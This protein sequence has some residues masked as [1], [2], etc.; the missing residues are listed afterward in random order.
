MGPL[1]Y[2]RHWTRCFCLDSPRERA[3]RRSEADAFYRHT[4]DLFFRTDAQAVFLEPYAVNP[5]RG[6]PWEIACPVA[7][8]ARYRERSGNDAYASL[9]A[10][11]PGAR[12]R[13]ATIV[14]ATRN[15][16]IQPSST[17]QCMYR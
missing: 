5:S 11:R 2:S 7:A 9:A 15:S 14:S 3:H 6:E 10:R 16:M 17:V 13:R 8:A 12:A 4:L 1:S